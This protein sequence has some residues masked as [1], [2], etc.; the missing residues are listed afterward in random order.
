MPKRG[1]SCSSAS[2]DASAIDAIA[3]ET[4][5]WVSCSL[6]P[7]DGRE[8]RLKRLERYF[9]DFLTRTAA[10]ETLADERAR[11]RLQ[12]SEIALAAGDAPAATKRLDEA[13]KAWENLPM[14][15]D[16]RFRVA[17]NTLLLA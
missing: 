11:A 3:C 12:L 6:P 13:L 2:I 4:S 15:A 16:L 17:T 7:L 10:I 8:L 5:A 1:G 9:E 14:D